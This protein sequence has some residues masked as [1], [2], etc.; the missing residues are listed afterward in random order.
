MI[1]LVAPITCSTAVSLRPFTRAA[2]P[3]QDPLPLSWKVLQM[4]GRVF[5][6]FLT[7]GF[8]AGTAA[9]ASE[10]TAKSIFDGETLQRWIGNKDL[11]RVEDGAITAE[12]TAGKSLDHNE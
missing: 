6:L 10:E 8:L 12:I 3:E 2:K 7:L 11:W 9:S 1:R 4:P 5:A